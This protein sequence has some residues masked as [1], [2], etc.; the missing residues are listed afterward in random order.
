MS[1]DVVVR[2]FTDEESL[3]LFGKPYAEIILQD[4]YDLEEHVNK[5]PGFTKI[6]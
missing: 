4:L 5:S 1:K 6:C 3:A 2:P